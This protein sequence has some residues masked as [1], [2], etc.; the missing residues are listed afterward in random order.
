[1]GDL[2][3]GQKSGDGSGGQDV[4]PGHEQ[5]GWSAGAVGNTR[6]AGDRSEGRGGVGE[7]G[8]L[9]KLA[10]M[11]EEE[12]QQMLDLR[13]EVCI[14]VRGRVAPSKSKI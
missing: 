9:Y 5:R 3:T 4:R 2:Y 12:R 14:I 7:S 11:S 13:E 8:A 6:G 10:G 1:M